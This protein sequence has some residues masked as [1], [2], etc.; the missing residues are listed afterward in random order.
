MYESGISFEYD[1]AESMGAAP[2]WIVSTRTIGVADASRDSERVRSDL[3]VKE[4]KKLQSLYVLMVT[5]E[6]ESWKG[7]RIDGCEKDAGSWLWS[8]RGRG[9]LVSRCT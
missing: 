4:A 7:R 3:I 8:G 2:L 1:D 9:F 6:K 5:A